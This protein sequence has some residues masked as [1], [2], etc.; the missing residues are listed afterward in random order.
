MTNIKAFKKESDIEVYINIM[1]D[2]IETRE[3]PE[4]R[5]K[6]WFI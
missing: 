2:L 5:Y 3:K 6:L 4:S 1:M